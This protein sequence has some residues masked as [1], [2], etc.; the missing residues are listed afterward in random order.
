MAFIRGPIQHSDTGKL[1]APRI[2]VYL[3]PCSIKPDA[4]SWQLICHDAWTFTIRAKD[5]QTQLYV[6]LPKLFAM[7]VSSG[8]MIMS[9]IR[10]AVIGLIVSYEKKKA[11]DVFS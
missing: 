5:T 8:C 2:P 6:T 9:R 1:S 7:T 11:A 3:S 10:A 4:T